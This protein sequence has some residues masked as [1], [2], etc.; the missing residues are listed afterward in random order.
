MNQIPHNVA[1][2]TEMKIWYVANNMGITHN[3]MK[4]LQWLPMEL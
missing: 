4:A 3:K 2:Y 1:R